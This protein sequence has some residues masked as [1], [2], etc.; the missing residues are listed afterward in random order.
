MTKKHFKTK[1]NEKHDIRQQNYRQYLWSAADRFCSAIFRLP[2]EQPIKKPFF[3][4][5]CLAKRI[6]QG[7][8]KK[9]I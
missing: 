4:L 8:K 9:K 6:F 3:D 2:F 5:F 1:K 7:F